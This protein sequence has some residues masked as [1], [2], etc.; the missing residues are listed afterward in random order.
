[1]LGHWTILALR[2]MRRHWFYSGIKILGLGIGIAAAL[3]ASLLVRDD[4]SF[5]RF[6]SHPEQLYRVSSV[7]EPNHYATTPFDL[8]GWLNLE[9]SDDLQAV[10]LDPD[11]FDIRYGAVETSETGYSVDRNIF[12]I[13]D[14]KFIAG[15]PRHALDE[16]NSVVMTASK[17]KKIFGTADAMG[18]QFE[19]IGGDHP[20]VRVTGILADLPNSTHLDAEILVS[21]TSAFSGLHGLDTATFAPNALNINVLTYIRRAAGTTPARLEADLQS[22]IASH[23]PPDRLN[24]TKYSLSADPITAIHL[25]PHGQS[26]RHGSDVTTVSALGAVGALLLVIAI[27]NYSNLVSAQAS[28]RLV[29]IGVRKSAGATRRH[30]AGQLFVEST[31]FTLFGLALGLGF[32]ELSL[33]ALNAILDRALRLDYAHDGTLDAS[34]LALVAFV[35]FVGGAYP[36]WTLSR[37]KPST[38]LK[39]GKDKSSAGPSVLQSLVVVQFA[40]GIGMIIATA[41]VYQQVLFATN[42]ALKFD[43]D[44]VL[45][46]RTHSGC[47]DAFKQ[48][49]L[50]RRG[51][52]AASCSWS[53]PLLN[54]SNAEVGLPDGSTQT[55]ARQSV[56]FGFFALY[57]LP[58][59]AGRDFSRDLQ[60][61]DQVPSDRDAPMTS[62]VVLNESAA[63]AFG[64]TSPA[65]AIGQQISAHR[66]FEATPASQTGKSTIIGVVA[67]FPVESVRSAI[68]PTVFYVDPSLFQILSV[69]LSRDDI[70]AGVASVDAVWHQMG[71]DALITRFF[72]DAKI[73]D[74]YET[75]M[76]EQSVFLVLSGLGIVVA[77]I[78][79]FGLAGYAAN[80]RTKE[81]GIR[82][83]LGATTEQLV[84]LLVWQ[85]IKPVVIANLIAWPVAGWLLKRWLDGFAQRVDLDPLIFVGAGGL[86]V[87]VA[88]LV[89]AGHA[90]NVA[91]SRPVTALRYE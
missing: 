68:S 86:A 67:D 50:T 56:D 81:I 65:A 36:A 19:S 79:L 41:V 71:P 75:L 34:I 40:I 10:R 62:S 23:Y 48:E 59:V 88:I 43:K 7:V 42:A 61:T 85:F 18:L 6:F 33:P 82:K 72:L 84:R 60:A 44:Q 57:H 89:T 49:L 39:R 69:K 28:S 13:L 87:A 25:D 35:G 91:R 21:G 20:Q 32:V 77:C 27:I 73:R 45:V 3:V 1:M 64:F 80:A 4:L 37:V 26:G 78:G 22:V 51:V 11:S 15:D 30:I 38:A 63:R 70:M 54:A 47:A 83:A 12:E 9:H 2:D 53:A 31:I 17:A 52:V 66:V 5:D 24:G 8:A 58:M 76:Q 46:V 90:I 14:L 16:P 74:Q 55:A 29:E